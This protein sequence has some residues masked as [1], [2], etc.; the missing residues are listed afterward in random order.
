MKI[1]V[2]AGG[3]GGHLFPAIAIGEELMLQ[4]HEVHLIT[5]LRC[6]KYLSPDL[7]LKTHII[8]SKLKNSGLF[9][10]IALLISFSV[11]FVRS[12]KLLFALK[13]DLIIGFG[14]YPTF[15]PLFA[16]LALKIP[17]M[18]HEQNC[19]LGKVNRFFA[20][21]SVKIGLAYEDTKNLPV[22]VSKEKFI[23]TGDIIRQ[24]VRDLP[25]K[26]GFA[27]DLFTIFIFGG[28]QSAKIFSTLVPEAVQKLQELAPKTKLQ[29]IQQ[30]AE[31]EQAQIAQRYSK[32]Q[33]AHQISDFFHNI[34]EQYQKADLVISRAGASTIAELSYIGMPAI[35][36]P[37]PFAA[38]DHQLHNAKAVEVAGGGWCYQQNMITSD[39][40]A[41]KILELIQNPALLEMA[42][43]SMLKRK[44]DGVK[45][46]AAVVNAV[47]HR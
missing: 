4:G 25:K 13:P 34:S 40:L 19:F 12:L 21:Y 5:D 17:I 33:I 16:S 38:E 2:S 43:E 9:A 32:L 15:P 31:G 35:F 24:N 47:F 6:Q 10:K 8:D 11:A 46:F 42:H 27:G 37:F 14:G 44:T 28:S 29:I 26:K 30:A 39:I 18:L 3:T 23:V 36:I 45:V 7:K 41:G 20:K 22:N 1:I